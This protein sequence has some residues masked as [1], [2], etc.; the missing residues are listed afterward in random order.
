MI[1]YSA[2]PNSRDVTPHRMSKATGNMSGEC[3]DMEEL[4]LY[5]RLNDIGGIAI[6]NF[7]IIEDCEK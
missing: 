5:I 4:Y 1:D 7:K 6:K 2:C 3:Q